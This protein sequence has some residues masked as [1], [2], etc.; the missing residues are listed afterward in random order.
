MRTLQE[1]EACGKEVLI[2]DDVAGYLGCHP[3]NLRIA[4][5]QAPE[6]LGFPF[7][8]IGT[9]MKIPREGFV[10]WAK[11]IKREGGAP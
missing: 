11:G 1:I 2:P 3:H 4:A 9:R 5:H 10:Q 6:L 8:I 7:T